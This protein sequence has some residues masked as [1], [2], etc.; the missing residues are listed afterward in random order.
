MLSHW[1]D[2][3]NYFVKHNSETQSAEM[4][5]FETLHRLGLCYLRWMPMRPG[6]EIDKYW[7]TMTFEDAKAWEII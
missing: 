5:M 4:A 1:D 2:S 3:G 6:D 7:T